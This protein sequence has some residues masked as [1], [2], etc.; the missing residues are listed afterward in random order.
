LLKNKIELIHDGERRALLTW[1]QRDD[2]GNTIPIGME[3]S[4]ALDDE[5]KQ[6]IIAVC[7][8]PVNVVE[9]GK[10]RKAFPGSSAHFTGLPKIL[11]RLGF[12]VREF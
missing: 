12:R 11:A 1:H 6:R 7:Q 10:P 2:E 5:T 3:F 8:R 4:D 9:A